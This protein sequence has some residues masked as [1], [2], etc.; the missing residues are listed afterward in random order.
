[1]LLWINHPAAIQPEASGPSVI[2][3]DL[4]FQQNS[5]TFPFPKK[6]PEN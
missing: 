4:Q 3:I 1:L 5:G 2:E 6:Q